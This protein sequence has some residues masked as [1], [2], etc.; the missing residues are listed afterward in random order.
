MSFGLL[1]LR[2]EKIKLCKRSLKSPSPANVLRFK[3]YRNLYNKLTKAAK[4]LYYDK[5]FIKHQT[6]IQK[7]WSLIFE[8]IRKSSPKSDAINEILVNN[9]IVND[10]LMMANCF[11]DFF[12]KVA[13]DIA[14]D[15]LPTD[16]P[17]DRINPDPG[18]PLFYFQDELVTSDEI[19]ECFKC[20]QKKNTP[21]ANG[22]SVQFIS[23]F[24]LTIS[25]PL[26]HIF[27]LSFSSGI[28]PVQLKIAKVIPIF[29]SGD[30]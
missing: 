19:V 1:T 22:L 15:I 13:Y 2:K 28:V 21:D 6:K 9:C 25:R 26:K 29:K 4:K 11:N 17:P 5:Q 14:E 23:N 10:P 8:A 18:A 30:K 3:N 20:L 24:A 27:N 16:R 12:T 7:T